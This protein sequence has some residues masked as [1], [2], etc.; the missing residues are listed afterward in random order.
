VDNA[1]SREP[2]RDLPPLDF[3]RVT[4][5]NKCKVCG[6]DHH[7]SEDVSRG[8]LVCMW[9][10]DKGGG[11][12][13]PPPAGY[14][15]AKRNRV[16]KTGG[17]V[18][19][20]E[21]QGA[22][23]VISP[24]ERA[25]R[26]AKDE[27][28]KAANKRKAVNVFL[29]AVKGH[30]RVAAYLR[31]RGID[32][33]SLPG[34]VPECLRFEHQAFDYAVEQEDRTKKNFFSPAMV[35]SVIDEYDVL[36]GCHRTYL[37]DTEPRKRDVTEHSGKPKKML[38]SC[39]G[40]AI[41]LR[42]EFP[43]GVLIL[44]EGIETALA[45]MAATGLTAWSYLSSNKGYTES[46]KLPA[47]YVGKAVWTVIVAAD[48]DAKKTGQFAAGVLANSLRTMYPSLRVVVR[49]P[50][51]AVCPDL[52]VAADVAGEMSV[53]APGVKG[54]D[55]LDVLRHVGPDAV[56]AG[57]LGGVD[58]GSKGG[59]Q[60]STHGLS[61]VLSPALP[62]V[63]PSVLA[64]PPHAHAPYPHSPK[65][66]S[67][68]RSEG[69]GWGQ[70]GAGVA[71]SPGD[72]EDDDDAWSENLNPDRPWQN[73]V[74]L[75]DMPV[76]SNSPME[77][78]RMFLWTK[79][80]IDEQD[81]WGVVY[82]AGAW[83]RFTGT[84]YTRLDDA[85]FRAQAW[86]WL[87]G[88]AYYKREKL[89]RLEPTTKTVEELLRAMITDTAVNAPAMPSFLPSTISRKGMPKWGYSTDLRTL[90]KTRSGGEASAA[91]ASL[92]ACI[93]FPNGVADLNE[94]AES[95]S[96]RL[97]PHSAKIFT[98]TCMPYA[99]PV[100]ELQDLIEHE[101]HDAVF[102]RLCPKFWRWLK[103]ASEGDAKWVAQ[104]QEMFGDTI[105]GDRSIEKIFAVI[106]VGRSGKGLLADALRA[107]CSEANCESV[108]L[109]ALANDPFALA[110]LVGKSTII[111]ED[112]HVSKLTG[113]TGLT[114]KLKVI[115]G[116]GWVSVRDMYQRPVSVKLP[117]RI[118]VFANNDPELRDDSA[119]LANRFIFLPMNISRL[120]AEDESIK[121][122]IPQEAPGIMLWAM[123]GAIRL[124]E[125][126]RRQI[127]LCD[128]AADMSYEYERDSA[129]L[130]GF[131]A[132]TLDVV[133]HGQDPLP[134]MSF[135]EMEAVY[136]WWCKE[137]KDQEHMTRTNFA[138]RVKWVLKSFGVRMRQPRAEDGSRPRVYEGVSVKLSVRSKLDRWRA[139]PDAQAASDLPF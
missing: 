37:H 85:I 126:D 57:L 56:R 88:F 96:V 48:V 20:L 95:R 116:Q 97:R 94:I 107:V 29:G 13:Q 7:C 11:V 71:I 83:W 54:V 77:R 39:A 31:A 23:P 113:Q 69:G 75:F 66:G 132:D 16:T 68:T 64:I 79:C 127:E 58:V 41:R 51:P 138:R 129:P 104:V 50:S 120:G 100:E 26:E 38:G 123:L 44:T 137:I 14:G 121:K 6:R 62:S 103:D 115:S 131:V 40:R 99:L 19:V 73:P 65:E 112:A 106:G 139:T 124:A 32:V 136:R 49:M 117:G 134:L 82:W 60:S 135:E 25:R 70:G 22:A 24:E 102:D 114:E 72:D 93:V 63:L 34:G 55:W 3:R 118:W 90:T 18:Y 45:C 133:K 52:V 128:E 84:H 101:E 5:Q 109:D 81:R 89:A 1:G 47:K 8:V 17:F 122:A 125:R 42:E 110:P 53:P 105:S 119:A 67:G 92:R 78:A 91:D 61:P 9:A 2:S 4:L 12:P 87:D 33:D 10:S 59:D 30:P 108:F 43:Q 28:A 111:A 21:G 76:I 86:S 130:K 27:A 98:A 36:T 46:L 74:A 15:W 35:A 80:R